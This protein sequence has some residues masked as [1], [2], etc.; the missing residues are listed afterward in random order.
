MKTYIVHYESEAHIGFRTCRHGELT[1]LKRIMKE[2]GEQITE[3]EYLKNG[4][5]VD[6]RKF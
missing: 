5:V 4:K 1:A 6:V 3:I 2:V